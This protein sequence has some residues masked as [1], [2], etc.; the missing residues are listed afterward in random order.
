MQDPQPLNSARPLSE[1]R[2]PDADR[3]APVAPYADPCAYL[4]P[5]AGPLGALARE[6]HALSEPLNR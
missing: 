1:R 2:W 5:D 6:F 4:L 3:A